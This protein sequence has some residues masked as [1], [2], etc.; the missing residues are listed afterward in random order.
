M[1]SER[2]ATNPTQWHLLTQQVSD[3]DQWLL[4]SPIYHLST[5][6]A[7]RPIGHG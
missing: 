5:P 1:L 6:V 3:L 2:I 4:A 7:R